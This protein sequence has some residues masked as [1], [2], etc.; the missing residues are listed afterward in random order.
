MKKYIH[1][2]IAILLFAS[3]NDIRVENAETVETYPD[4]YPN[5]K[6]VTVPATIAPLN[7][8]ATE[9]SVEAI[10]ATFMGRETSYTYSSRASIDIDI[11]EWHSLLSE[12]YGDTISVSV[13]MKSGDKWKTYKKFQIAVS[14]DSIDYGLHYRLIAP[15]YGIYS[16]MGLYERNLSNFDVKTIYAGT[17]LEGGCMNCHTSNKCDTKQSSTHFRG[18]HGA[19]VIR[20]GDDYQLFNLKTDSEGLPCVYTYWH[21]SG[22]YIG[23]SQSMTRQVYHVA[24]ADKIEVYDSESDIAVLDIDNKKL[25]T[26]PLLKTDYYEAAPTFS[27]DGR[28]MY[29]STSA[30]CNLPGEYERVKY[31]LCSIS[32]D[33]EKG[34]FGEKVDTLI[35]SRSEGKSIAWTTPSY[36]GRFLIFTKVDYGQFSVWHHEADLWLYDIKTKK[37]HSLDSANSEDTDSYHNWSS[38][39]RWVVFT[40][41]R[42]DGYH[43]L[44]YIVHIDEE[45]IASKAFLLPQRNPREYYDQEMKSYNVPDF[46]LGPT[47]YDSNVVESLLYGESREKVHY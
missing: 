18:A 40:S 35:D 46:E 15:G 6:F 43:S 2:A 37:I 47:N 17:K 4:I 19:T 1:I 3:C 31:V 7:F 32:F 11:D 34:V 16:D 9:D 8:Q 13:S 33:P 44:P 20:R 12:N 14:T 41:R 28:T 24:D 38:N 45:G 21:P 27:P 22:K 10:S 39:S 29:F 42:D 5:Y 26:S 36:D 25:L 30:P 23:Y